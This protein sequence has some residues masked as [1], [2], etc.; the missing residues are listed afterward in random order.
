M[1]DVGIEVVEL[2]R[3][4]R[5]STLAVLLSLV[6][7]VPLCQHSAYLYRNLVPVLGVVNV[8]ASQNP[9]CQLEPLSV[10]EKLLVGI[11]WGVIIRGAPLQLPRHFAARCLREMPCCKRGLGP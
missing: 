4:E 10:C 1:V 11:P 3:V 9:R 7:P 5:N 8:S 6:E 2:R